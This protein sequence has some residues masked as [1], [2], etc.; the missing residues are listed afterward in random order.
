MSRASFRRDCNSTE[1]LRRT[2]NNRAPRRLL[3]VDA[4]RGTGMGHSTMGVANLVELGLAFDRSLRI[5]FCAPPA[6]TQ[7]FQPP[8]PSC[9]RPHFDLLEYLSLPYVRLVQTPARQRDSHISTLHLKLHRL[10]ALG[11]AGMCQR[12]GQHQRAGR[13]S[14]MLG[15]HGTAQ[16]VWSSSGSLLNL[17]IR[18]RFFPRTARYLLLRICH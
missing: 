10:T 8:M 12:S 9:K 13:A 11:P 2:A 18:P 16:A 5:A 3:L 14:H 4:W 15:S 1:F 6:L 7:Y 17:R